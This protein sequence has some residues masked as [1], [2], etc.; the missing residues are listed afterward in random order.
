MFWTTSQSKFS[1]MVPH[2]VSCV[3]QPNRRIDADSLYTKYF[4][5][6]R[7]LRPF[8]RPFSRNNKM[9][10]PLLDVLTLQNILRFVTGSLLRQSQLT[11]WYLSNGIFRPVRNGHVLRSKPISVPTRRQ[12]W[13]CSRGLFQLVPNVVLFPSGKSRKNLSSL[14]DLLP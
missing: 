5:Y 6:G 4:K 2:L 1:K 13:K 12:T 9:Y 10:S 11:W 14:A 8:I 3:T 7:H